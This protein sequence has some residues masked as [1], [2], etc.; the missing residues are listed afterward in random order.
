[1]HDLLQSLTVIPCKLKDHAIRWILAWILYQGAHT[2]LQF[3]RHI[4]VT[5]FRISGCTVSPN[6][7]FG[8]YHLPGRS[9]TNE[10]SWVLGINN[11]TR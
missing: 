9:L 7:E 1:M 6:L 2:L 11:T 10:R 8:K 3:L 5:I 4:N